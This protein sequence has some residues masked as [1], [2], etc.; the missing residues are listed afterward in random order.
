MN[1]SVNNEGRQPLALVATTS[2]DSHSWNLVI[3]ALRL[4]ARGFEVE[5]L[6]ANTPEMLLAERIRDRR[7]DLV[8]L[9]TINGHGYRSIPGVLEALKRYQVKQAAPLVLGG[10]LTTGP[11]EEFAMAELLSAEGVSAV[12]SGPEAWSRFDAFLARSCLVGAPGS[13][14]RG[15]RPG[16]GIST[17]KKSPRT[18]SVHH[19]PD[20]DMDADLPARSRRRNIDLER[21]RSIED[22]PDWVNAGG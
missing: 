10:L 12:F 17:S 22:I 19:R 9:S 3:V 18:G 15:P 21:V 13:G 4:E 20:A 5:N 1:Y 2:D 11:E 7:P 16:T 14:R 6:G 8:T